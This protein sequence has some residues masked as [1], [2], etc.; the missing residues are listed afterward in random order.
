M[1]TSQ[2]DPARKERAMTWRNRT[3]A[4]HSAAEL[5]EWVIL[6]PPI[7]GMASSVTVSIGD[8]TQA[9]RGGRCSWVWH[10]VRLRKIVFDGSSVHVSYRTRN[11]RISCSRHTINAIWGT[12]VSVLQLQ[13]YHESDFGV[14]RIMLPQALSCQYRHPMVLHH[15]V[16][17]PI[18]KKCKNLEQRKEKKKKCKNRA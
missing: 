5:L 15:R 2:L 14:Q 12:S 6:T 18:Q 10:R 1:R 17:S 7:V 8:A 9:L 3:N 13:S 16:R 11:S 4:A